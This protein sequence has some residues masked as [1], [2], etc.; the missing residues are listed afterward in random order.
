MSSSKF[1][2][3]VHKMAIMDVRENIVSL[4]KKISS[5]RKTKGITVL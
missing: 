5:L 2:G 1:D 3:P 4:G